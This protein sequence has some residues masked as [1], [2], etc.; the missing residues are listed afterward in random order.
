[1]ASQSDEESEQVADTQAGGT[2][3][4]AVMTAVDFSTGLARRVFSDGPQP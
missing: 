4:S 2:V 1:M 3:R